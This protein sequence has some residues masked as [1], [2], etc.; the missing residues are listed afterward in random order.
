MHVLAPKYMFDLQLCVFML[1]SPCR[2]LIM[3]VWV[4]LGML[5]S[6]TCLIVPEDACWDPNI[7]DTALIFS[8]EPDYDGLS[9]KMRAL[10]PVCG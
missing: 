1:E 9:T 3:H 4:P 8:F 10:V 5:G 7:D 2:R 6:H